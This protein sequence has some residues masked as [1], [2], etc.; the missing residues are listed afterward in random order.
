MVVRALGEADLL[1]ATLLSDALTAGC[2]EA[3]PDG[4]LVAD[5]TG[6]TFLGS[7]GLAELLRCRRRCEEQ[8]TAMRVVVTSELRRVLDIAGLV[9][10][11]DVTEST[12][13]SPADAPG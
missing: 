10:V 12:P 1:T 11:L 13:D 6:V 4:T 8:G 7:A 9:K 3:G 5:L 2:T